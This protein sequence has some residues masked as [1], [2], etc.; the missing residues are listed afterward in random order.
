MLGFLFPQEADLV[1]MNIFLARIVY[2][3]HPLIPRRI[4]TGNF[5]PYRKLII[6]PNSMIV[7]GMSPQSTPSKNLIMS[8]LLL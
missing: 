7:V 1:Q 3:I 4:A 6:T 5:K 8:E 2:T